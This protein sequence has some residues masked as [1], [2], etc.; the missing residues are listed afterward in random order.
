MEASLHSETLKKEEEE[1]NEA[2]ASEEEEEGGKGGM[3]NL[4]ISRAKL[5]VYSNLELEVRAREMVFQGPP[6]T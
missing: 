6:K 3:G 4:L 2:R 1:K 5:F